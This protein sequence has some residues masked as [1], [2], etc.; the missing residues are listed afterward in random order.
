MFNTHSFLPWISSGNSSSLQAQGKGN[1][2]VHIGSR[3]PHCPWRYEPCRESNE[4]RM[5]AST[6]T[7]TT[8]PFKIIIF[9]K[10]TGFTDHWPCIFCPT[11]TL[12]SAEL[13]DE[14]SLVGEKFLSFLHEL[15]PTLSFQNWDILQLYKIRKQKQKKPPKTSTYIN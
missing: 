15:F 3:K 8:K 6:T 2:C 4:R 13:E 12:E 10:L 11:P 7:T 9:M 14:S 5:K 1:S